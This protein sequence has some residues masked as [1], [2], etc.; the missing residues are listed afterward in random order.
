M[1]VYI[2]YC[3]DII[4]QGL[5]MIFVPLDRFFANPYVNLFLDMLMLFEGRRMPRR[6]R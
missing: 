3:L 1:F 6:R 4:M 2:I 5:D